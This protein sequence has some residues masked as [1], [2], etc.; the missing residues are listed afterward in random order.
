MCLST[1]SPFSCSSPQN[2]QAPDGHLLP[3][4]GQ[5]L[6]S[7]IALGHLLLAFL[8]VTATYVQ[9]C[10][11]HIMYDHMVQNTIGFAMLILG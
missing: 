8:I 11:F 2:W 1:E 5:E 10:V 6:A 4:L 3:L 9:K 7:G